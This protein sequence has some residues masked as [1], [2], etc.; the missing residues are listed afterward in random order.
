MGTMTGPI[1][2]TLLVVPLRWRMTL[3][4][5]S[6]PSFIWGVCTLTLI[7]G[8][9]LRG[10]GTQNTED[11]SNLSKRLIKAVKN[12]NVLGVTLVQALVIGG[13]G[14]GF[15]TNYMPLYLAQELNMGVVL[16]GF[17]YTLML[18]GAVLGPLVFGQVSDRLG[19]KKTLLA[20]ILCSVLS[21]FLLIVVA[22]FGA[23][24]VAA[25]L[26]LIGL[27]SFPITTIMQT[28]VA[29][30]TDNTTRNVVI[31]FH[32]A[33]GQGCSSLWMILVGVLTDTYGSF[34]P[35]IY[36]MVIMALASTLIALFTISETKPLTD[37]RAHET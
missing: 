25:T 36:L 20:I 14:Y 1:A 11:R 28:I 31:G 34:V 26:F 30:A 18:L 10:K 4:V 6:L 8:K 7:K 35:S 24:I 17:V 5:L 22:P 2:A 15:L 37:R 16:M 3:V 23:P 9:T 13:T 29:D 27:F 19:R 32:L 12:K 21:L 33:V